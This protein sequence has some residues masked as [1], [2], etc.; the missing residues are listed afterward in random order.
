MK[1]GLFLA[2]ALLA[3]A[4]FTTPIL[5]QET[6]TVNVSGEP[7][8]CVLSITGAG[9][10]PAG[11]LV[12]IEAKPTTN[13]RF[14]G[15]EIVKGLGFS[16]TSS[17]PL[18]FYVDGDFEAKAV[19]ERLYTG[20]GGEVIER[21]VIN[22]VLNISLPAEL[23]P[24]PVIAR[25]G[26]KIRYVFQPEILIQDRKYVYLYAEALGNIYASQEVV[27]QA[28]AGVTNVT[29]FYYTY[30]RFLDEYYPLNQFTTLKAESVK[31][32][33]NE[34]KIPVYYTV[35]GKQFPI[36]Q[37]IP[38]QLINLAQVS[39]VTQY[40][41]TIIA[42][43]AE[44]TLTIN[45][46]EIPVNG[47]Y[48]FWA[49][50]GSTVSIAC[51]TQLGKH[52]LKSVDSHGI[53]MSSNCLGAGIATGPAVI[54]LTYRPIPN[55][56]F[57]DIPYVGGLVY[58]VAEVGRQVTGLEGYPSLIMGL[59]ITLA[60]P[61]AAAA[62]AAS[63]RKAS[64]LVRAKGGDRRRG[65]DE[66]LQPLLL[67][68]S[69][70]EQ[71]EAVDEALKA[72][73][74]VVV[75]EELR[76]ALAQSLYTHEEN[77]ADEAV[78]ELLEKISTEAEEAVARVLEGGKAS[79][80]P[81]QLSL[82]YWDERRFEEFRQAVAEKR[83]KI[84]DDK[85]F[86]GLDVYGQKIVDAIE[87]G[88][89]TLV[90]KTWDTHLGV[91]LAA[92]ACARTGRKPQTL[93]PPYGHKPKQV[94]EDVR[95]RAGSAGAVIF[96]NPDPESEKAIVQASLNTKKVHIIVSENTALNPTL[97]IPELGDEE[98]I[99][100]AIALAAGEKILTRLT[101]RNIEHL[102]KL[103]SVDGYRTI[104]K[105]VAHLKQAFEEEGEPDPEQALHQFFLN[106]LRRVFTSAEIELL[107]QTQS[108][109][110]LRAAYIALIRQVNPGADPVQHWRRF[111]TRLK[112]LGMVV[113]E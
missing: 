20:P 77:A 112:R 34:R 46:Q 31:V 110:Q 67:L 87:K 96:V 71:G 81:Y 9:K 28:P 12:K 56:Q 80:Q 79:I 72:S 97:E 86:M 104:E 25:V 11:A 90:V 65:G 55:A 14:I 37:P 99:P 23:R 2:T 24:Q 106:E 76:N 41:F 4:L 83:A 61:A 42:E 39:Y 50:A 109:E 18:F 108:V 88:Y 113:E 43:G 101:L 57:Q 5:G 102:A 7:A 44:T 73:G 103:A 15:W 51:R 8:D 45:G 38:V 62:A 30:V 100:V 98:Y 70:R 1:T 78:D 36:N 40:R 27:L 89:A 82:V 85:G 17:N 95:K 47:V 22:P 32:N 26:E 111:H 49:D 10:F 54:L 68:A 53:Q 35:A 33:E 52:L 3:L 6:Y 16:Y 84:G 66:T 13:C 107:T 91:A 60:P 93:E 58:A 105:A 74:R 59:T 75:P 63:A 69:P 21:A 64:A 19:F 94:A 48:Q 29:A 92:E